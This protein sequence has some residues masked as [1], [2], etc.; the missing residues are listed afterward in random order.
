MMSRFNLFS[1]LQSCSILH[2]HLLQTWPVPDYCASGRH[3]RCGRHRQS[4]WW[5]SYCCWSWSQSWWSRQCE[6]DKKYHRSWGEASGREP[7]DAGGW[8]DQHIWLL[9]PGHPRHPLP[10]K[11][12]ADLVTM[13]IVN[14]I[15]PGLPW[16]LLVE[17]EL[18]WTVSSQELSSSSVLPFSCPTVP[19]F[20]RSNKIYRTFKICKVIKLFEC[21]MRH[22]ISATTCSNFSGHWRHFHE[23]YEWFLLCKALLGKCWPNLH[24]NK[25]SISCLCQRFKRVPRWNYGPTSGPCAQIAVFAEELI[26]QAAMA[27]DHNQAHGGNLIWQKSPWQRHFSFQLWI[28]SSSWLIGRKVSWSKQSTR[29]WLKFSSLKQSLHLG[30]RS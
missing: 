14:N 17:F 8:L 2:R 26:I 20:L 16:T 9:R 1:A 12:T 15:L 28:G 3:H 19:L 21:H 6:C 23:D 27:A 4:L 18:R 30:N 7:G 22:K 24:L 25:S 11:V 5:E 13:S 10:V 29:F